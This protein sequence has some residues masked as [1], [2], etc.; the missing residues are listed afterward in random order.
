MLKFKLEEFNMDDKGRGGRYTIF[1]IN[2]LVPESYLIPS[3]QNNIDIVDYTRLDHNKTLG[4]HVHVN[5]LQII[6]KA[7]SK[8]GILR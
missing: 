2:K 6:I 7:A 5:G 8:K 4:I 3:P 1:L